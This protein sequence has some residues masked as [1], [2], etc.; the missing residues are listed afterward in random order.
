MSTYT[1]FFWDHDDINDAGVSQE[2]LDRIFSW[3]SS[4]APAP[5]PSE[6]E[7]PLEPKPDLNPVNL[8]PTFYDP[9]PPAWFIDNTGAIFSVK[10]SVSEMLYII[11][12]A[13]Y[14]YSQVPHG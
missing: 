10:P 2:E 6:L 12:N 14:D 9:A 3:R 1:D 7:A 11:Y 8:I 5:V 13:H 4:P